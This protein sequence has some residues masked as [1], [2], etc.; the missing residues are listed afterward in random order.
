MNNQSITHEL[1]VKHLVECKCILPQFRKMPIPPFHK[2]VVFS[3]LEEKTGLVKVSFTQCP[4]CGAVH[5]I[6]E[7]GH[8]K[9]T[10]KDSLMSLPTIEDIKLEL[11]DKLVGLLERHV[12]ELPVWQEAKFILEHNLWGRTIILTRE[13]EGDLVMGKFVIVLGREIYKVETFE[14]NDSPI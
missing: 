1:Y 10:S 2:F 4:N 7:V 11:P 6:T 9:I 3:E 8:S 13:H 5:Y 12:C 14:R